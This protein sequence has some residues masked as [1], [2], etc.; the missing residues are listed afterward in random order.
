MPRAELGASRR[1]GSSKH[2]GG[3]EATWRLEGDLGDSMQVGG[4]ERSRHGGWQACVRRRGDHWIALGCFVLPKRIDA[5][6]T[7]SQFQVVW[8]VPSRLPD[9]KSPRGLQDD[10][11][12]RPAS[13]PPSHPH[14]IQDPRIFNFSNFFNFFKFSNFLIF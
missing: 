13:E 3:L 6:Q 4:F 5:S 8:S 12:T 9:S 1:A 14:A 7:P 10:W 11:K 2:L